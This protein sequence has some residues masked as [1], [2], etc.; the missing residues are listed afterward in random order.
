MIGGF[1]F[2]EDILQVQGLEYGLQIRPY[3]DFL[4]GGPGT[5]ARL[6]AV[7]GAPTGSFF[8][9]DTSTTETF[10]QDNEAWSVFATVD[11]HVND[12]LTLTGGLNYT[13]DRKRVTG[14]T[15][16]NDAFG[17]VDFNQ[18]FFNAA[19]FMQTALAPTPENIA[20][21]ESMAPG[22]TAALNAFAESSAAPL[23]PLQFQPQF[24]A[25]PNSVEAGRSMDEQLTWTARLAYDWTDNTNVYFSAATGFKATSWNLSR[26]SRPFF[27]D[28]SALQ[29]DGLLPN[30]YRPG[31]SLSTSINFGTRFA[32]PEEAT[33][34]EI[35]LKARFPRG[36]FNI[37]LFDQT[38]KGFQSNIF[39]G[40]GF[41]LGNAGKQST[42][43]I[44]LDATW[45]PIDELTLTFAGTYLDPVYDDFQN[46]PGPGG[47][48][49]DASG[50]RPADIHKFSITTSATYNHPF[51]SGAYG[52][53]RADYIHESDVQIS[54]NIL[55]VNREVNQFNASAGIE[56]KGGWGV[57]VFARNLFND[58]HFLSA[59]PGVIQDGTVNAYANAPRL[60]GV[61]LAYNF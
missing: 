29:A 32:G 35:G 53:I 38:I 3:I 30:N 39:Q 11:L 44:E 50:N 40:S 13:E 55:G 33:V 16:N 7:S 51:A 12:R 18:A 19:F 10:T 4:A 58:E 56:F 27:A 45:T 1:Y 21:I 57:S 14:S 28:G 52:F 37:A 2:K 48:V 61:S 43:G 41:V 22:T 36:A 54:N 60:W 34:Y 31:S 17:N 20:A 15:L 6:E 42:K 25:F 9:A 49:I 23:R 24:L 26:D 47:T 59:F 8:S 46:A 5:L